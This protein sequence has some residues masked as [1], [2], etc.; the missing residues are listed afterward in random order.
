MFLVLEIV[1]TVAGRNC[2]I[3]FISSLRPQPHKKS[4]AQLVQK[5]LWGTTRKT[6]LISNCQPDSPSGVST[7]GLWRMHSWYLKE[8]ETSFLCYF[9][10]SC[11]L[12]PHLQHMEV[13]RLGVKSELQLLTCA[14][15]IATRVPS[16]VWD[17]YHHSQQCQILNPL[18]EARDR[19][20]VLMDT[21]WVHCC[22]ATI[23][24]P[25]FLYCLR[26]L[27]QAPKKL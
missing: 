4:L 21:S 5:L 17:L 25:C 8:A 15:V 23:G 6:L 9:F 11:F 16:L 22:W 24:T 19:A 20:Q 26:L 7:R 27:S 14:I 3:P 1:S 18:S 2:C 10:F 12:G 13:T